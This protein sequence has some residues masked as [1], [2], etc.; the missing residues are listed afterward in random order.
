MKT[1][2]TKRAFR[3]A[4]RELERAFLYTDSLDTREAISEELKER[5][6][7]YSAR[8]GWRLAKDIYKRPA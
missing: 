6:D 7:S 2:N 1:S 3:R 8:K 4:R 5:F